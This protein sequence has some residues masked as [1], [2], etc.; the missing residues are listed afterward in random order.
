[1]ND[2]V[3]DAAIV[4]TA[5][6]DAED[7]R[8]WI[9]HARSGDFEAAWCASDRIRQRHAFRLDSTLPRH[10]QQVW[11]GG[12]LADRRVLVRCYHGLGDTIQFI[13]YASLLRRIAR[14]VIVW[15]QQPLLPLLRGVEGIDRL[16]PLHDGTPD[17]EYDVDIEVMELPYAFRTTLATIPNRVP[18]LNALPIALGGRGP[19]VGIV[20]RAGDWDARRSIP[21][22]LIAT[23]FDDARVSWYALQL[24]PGSA[25]RH[26]RLRALGTRGLLRTARAMCAMNLVISIDSMTA[27]LAGALGVPVWTLLPH[28]AD[29][30]WLEQRSDSPWYPTMRLFRQ[31]HPGSWMPLIDELRTALS[32]HAFGPAARLQDDRAGGT[33]KRR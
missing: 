6:A 5:A 22:E 28:D 11:Q 1:M 20:W 25:E 30:R 2:A 26:P 24:D 9:R 7:A 4:D 32:V 23:M 19:R 18:Y 21:Y 3:R 17:V 14:R 10:V 31:R 12:T 8:L 33:T 27:H 16:L 15:A 13:R 29:W